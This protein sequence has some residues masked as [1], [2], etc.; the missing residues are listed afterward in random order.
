MSAIDYAKAIV[1]DYEEDEGNYSMGEAVD[2][3]RDLIRAH[4]ALEARKLT[5]T[6]NVTSLEPDVVGQAVKRAVDAQEQRMAQAIP[7][8]YPVGDPLP[9]TAKQKLDPRLRKLA[10]EQTAATKQP[11]EPGQYN[12]GFAPY[13]K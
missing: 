8:V 6:V 3:L 10:A 13:S 5:V 11:H 4:E 2:A 7:T 1:R 9:Q 12:T